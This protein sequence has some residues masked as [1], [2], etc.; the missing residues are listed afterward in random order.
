MRPSDLLPLMMD[1]LLYFAARSMVVCLQLLPLD[2]VARLGRVF[3]SIAYWLDRRHRRV[4]QKNLTWCLSDTLSPVEI[5]ACVREHF[6]RLG[7]NYCSAIKTAS[8]SKES[9]ASRVEFVGAEHFVHNKNSVPGG[10]LVA[11][12]GHFGNFEIY[13]RIADCF[14]DYRGATTYRAL[15]Q[16]SLTRLV[17]SLRANSRCLFF[18]R[19]KDAGALRK[20]MSRGGILLG[21]LADQHGGDRGLP[22]PFF[23]K[24]C[25]TNPGPALFALRYQAPLFV[26]ICYRIG[27]ARWRIECSELIA[28]HLDGVPRSAPDI[29][30]EVNR[31]YEAAIRR[32][33][34]N[35]F[36][37]H[38]RWKEGKHRKPTRPVKTSEVLNAT[39]TPELDE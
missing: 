25:S 7:E 18:E 24:I 27:L 20:A 10:S 21:L 30:S 4:A 14:Q 8:M 5:H 1:S 33:P 13:A 6:R 2:C 23:G 28:T 22:L 12:I 36:W 26:V 11:A 16:P 34:A 37:V 39:S 32:D 38:N 17:Q 29:M 19:R 15:R 3:G 31:H 35:W 9:L